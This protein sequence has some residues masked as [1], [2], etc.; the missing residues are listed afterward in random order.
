RF[1]RPFEGLVTAA[2][3]F[4][5]GVG[6]QMGQGAELQIP[7]VAA[8]ALSRPEIFQPGIVHRE[9]QQSPHRVGQ[10]ELLQHRCRK[11]VAVHNSKDSWVNSKRC[12]IGT[13]DTDFVSAE[14]RQHPELTGLKGV[15]AFRVTKTVAGS[16]RVLVVTYNPKLAHTQW[17]TVQNDIT[18]A[19]QRLAELQGRLADRAAGLITGG[20]RPTLASVQKQCRTALRRQHLQDVIQV[21]VDEGPEGLPRVTYEL[22]AAAL[23][24]VAETHLGKTILISNREEWSDEQIIEAYR[25][26]YLIEAIFKDMKDRTTGSW[27]PL[28]HWT[29]SKLRVHGLYCSMA[30][31]LRSVMWR[32]VRRAGVKISLNVYGLESA[33]PDLQSTF[34]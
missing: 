16:E 5:Q 3:V 22:N 17:L 4:Q 27:W 12:Q 29:D 20:K 1:L 14:K 32:R 31:L 23:Q 26:Q 15:K 8:S 24:R 34:K 9:V 6:D 2:A 18:K 19:S 13:Y 28:N 11:N 10:G 25:S 21:T 30:Q 7:L 33:K